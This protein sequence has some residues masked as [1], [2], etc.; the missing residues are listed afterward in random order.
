MQTLINKNQLNLT[1][2]TAA[3]GGTTTSLVTTGEKYTW[4][5]KPDQMA[6]VTITETS[7]SLNVAENT[8]YSCSNPLTSLTI[9]T[10]ANSSL[11]SCINF[12]VGSGFALNLEPNIKYSGDIPS[13]WT[14]GD[15]YIVSIMFGV[16]VMVKTQT[17]TSA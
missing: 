1:S 13:S 17:V 5:N 10:V 12:T 7:V 4:N 9:L 8:W 15:T 3:S 11:E 2:E 6:P 14:E 16:V